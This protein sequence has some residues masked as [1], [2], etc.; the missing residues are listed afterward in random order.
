MRP[1][2]T[3]GLFAVRFPKKQYREA[4]AFNDATP[5]LPALKY[6][7]DQDPSATSTG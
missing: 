3:P 4:E 2:S 1:G 6:G 5:D 7:P